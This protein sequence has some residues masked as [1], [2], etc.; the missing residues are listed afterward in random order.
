MKTRFDAVQKL[1]KH[2]VTTQKK[3][4]DWRVKGRKLGRTPTRR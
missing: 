3:Y 1:L 2:V 4:A